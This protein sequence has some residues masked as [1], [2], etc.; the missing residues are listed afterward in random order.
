MQAVPITDPEPVTIHVDSKNSSTPEENA[1]IACRLSLVAHDGVGAWRNRWAIQRRRR[2][3]W[4]GRQARRAAAAARKP[5]TDP[6]AAAAGASGVR[7]ARAA[8][9]QLERRSDAQFPAGRIASMTS[10]DARCCATN[11]SRGSRSRTA[12]ADTLDRIRPN[13]PRL[14]SPW[15]NSYRPSTSRR[16]TRQRA[17][18]VV[19]LSDA[20]QR[21]QY[22][23]LKER[24]NRRVEQVQQ[25]STGAP[26][27]R[28]G[29]PPPL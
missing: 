4:R 24:F 21:A 28:R 14:L 1:V 20:V 3:A 9:A 5:T 26:G 23:A 7:P 12:M 8:A 17:E 22:F 10:S 29:A 27:G 15:T 11:V 25:D 6:G 16:I 13:R 18:G 19:G 2:P